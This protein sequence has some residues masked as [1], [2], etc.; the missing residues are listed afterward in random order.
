MASDYFHFFRKE[1]E[2]ERKI[3]NRLTSTRGRKNRLFSV[4]CNN[5]EY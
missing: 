1:K 2:E 5:D 3:E 4:G